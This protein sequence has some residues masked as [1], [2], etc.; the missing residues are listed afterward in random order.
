V[1]GLS[2]IGLFV[3]NSIQLYGSDVLAW[4]T[5]GLANIDTVVVLIIVSW[6]V[7]AFIGTPFGMW[8]EQRLRS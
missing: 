6:L 1:P 4:F 5:S 7:G 8:V 2:I 3:G